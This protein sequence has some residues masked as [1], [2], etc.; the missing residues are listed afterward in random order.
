MTSSEAREA[1]M[2]ATLPGYTPEGDP[3]TRRRDLLLVLGA[4]G[5]LVVLVVLVMTGFFNGI[6]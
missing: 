4:I 5:V 3:Q 2:R 1:Q 6:L